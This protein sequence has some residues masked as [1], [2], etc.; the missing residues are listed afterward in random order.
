MK[1]FI[2]KNTW[3]KGEC[4][5]GNGYVI[6]PKNHIL[7]KTDHSYLPVNL[8]SNLTFSDY[9]HKLPRIRETDISINNYG[10]WI[11]GFD[12]ADPYYSFATK[13]FVELET[14]NLLSQLEKLANA[15]KLVQPKFGF[16]CPNCKEFSEL[17]EEY[18]YS[19]LRK[20]VVCETC[21]NRCLTKV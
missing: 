13:D 12:T 1:T 17:P 9:V 3:T 21:T 8:T 7:Y 16:V 6:I 2:R 14:N 10:D 5:W 4:G 20:V 18:Y 15:I 11:V 19:N